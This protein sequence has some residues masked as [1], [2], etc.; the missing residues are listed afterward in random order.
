[1]LETQRGERVEI[2]LRADAAGR[3]DRPPE[4]SRDALEQAQVRAGQRP[5]A[6]DRRA[7]DSRD[8]RVPASLDRLVDSERRRA[9]P[10]VCPDDTV[11]NV[12]G[13]DEPVTER[14]GG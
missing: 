2:R 4:P 3:E 8:A 11:A 5:V 7:E 13:D 6:V 12:D 9:L 10:A 1:A 14:G